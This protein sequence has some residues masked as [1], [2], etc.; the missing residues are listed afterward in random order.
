MI[1]REAIPTPPRS[2]MPCASKH[3]KKDRSACQVLVSGHKRS[4]YNDIHR[5]P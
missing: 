4:R 2:N 3:A 1:E 5:T